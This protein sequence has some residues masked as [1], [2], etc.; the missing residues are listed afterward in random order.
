MTGEAGGGP[1][2]WRTWARN[3]LRFGLPFA[4]IAVI[5]HYVVASIGGNISRAGFAVGI[6]LILASFSARLVEGR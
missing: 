3:A 6:L 5:V 4:G 2:T 1:I